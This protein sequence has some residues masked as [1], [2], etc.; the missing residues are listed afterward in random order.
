MVR[1]TAFLC[2]LFSAG[3]VHAQ[4]QNPTPGVTLLQF[5]SPS[6]GPCRSM[7]PKVRRLHQAGYA[8]RE[9]DVT[10]EPQLAERY[11]V[12]SLPTFVTVVGNREE[13]RLVGA[14]SQAQLQE[15]M[16]KSLRIAQARTGNALS[17][18]SSNPE[19]ELVGSP[20]PSRTVPQNRIVDVSSRQGDAANQGATVQQP[21]QTR[22]NLGAAK[23]RAA[24]PPTASS[25]NANATRISPD[26]LIAASVRL[27]VE[28]R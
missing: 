18:R 3:I 26:Q 1:C 2:L 4:A 16:H 28:D 11:R 8:V 27:T 14:T 5:S 20:Q 12:R 15:M 22:E 21:A 19:F 7:R 13:G 25:Q 10:R 6:C 17:E 24:W 9:I 23:P